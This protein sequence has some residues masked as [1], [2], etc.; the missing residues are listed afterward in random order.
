[1]IYTEFS[2]RYFVLGLYKSRDEKIWHLYPFPFVRL[3][4]DFE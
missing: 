3:T 1:M 2:W 4:F